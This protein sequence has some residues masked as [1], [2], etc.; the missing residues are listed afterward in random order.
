MVLIACNCIQEFLR[1]NSNMFF[2]THLFWVILPMCMPAFGVTLN[3]K[4]VFI[5]VNQKR[6]AGYSP[7]GHKEL[8]TTEAT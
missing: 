7:W 6:L 4:E 8:D 2:M 5:S 3:W 1:F